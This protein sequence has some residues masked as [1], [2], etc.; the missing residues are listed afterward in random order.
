MVLNLRF[1][2]CW[3]GK[4]RKFPFPTAGGGHNYF[5]LYTRWS[6]FSERYIAA[7]DSRI[8]DNIED[9]PD[10]LALQMVRDL[11]CKRYTYRD[12][13]NKGSRT[14]IGFIAQEV[15]DVIPEAVTQISDFIPDEY[16]LLSNDNIVWN[17]IDEETY[18]LTI[19]DLSPSENTFYRL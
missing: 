7:S 6:I 17:S 3:G 16:R 9:L 5:S 19:T 2:Y 13:I 15:K 8:K 12:F 11:S 10:D 14:T 4:I 1:R 18:N